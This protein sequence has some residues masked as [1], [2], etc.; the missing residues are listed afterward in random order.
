LVTNIIL[1]ALLMFPMRLAG[2]ALAT[3]L[4]G[5]NSC[6]IL[7]FLLKKRIH[8]F[9]IKPIVYSF[10]RI[11]LA[12]LCMGV[13]CWLVSLNFPI[14]DKILLRVLGLGIEMAAGLL[15]YIVFCFI[16]KVQEIRELWKWFVKKT[17]A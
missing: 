1:N 8:P 4:A 2:L 17:K 11:L 5:I 13:V 16:F 9:D 12:S 6:L 7:L 14:K 15:A 10:M 3:S